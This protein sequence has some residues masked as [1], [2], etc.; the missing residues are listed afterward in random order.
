MLCRCL[1]LLL[2]RKRQKRLWRSVLSRRSLDWRLRRVLATVF[3]TFFT[4]LRVNI[5]QYLKPVFPAVCSIMTSDVSKSNVGTR[6]NRMSKFHK[7][8]SPSHRTLSTHNPVHMMLSPWLTLVS[9]FHWV[10]SQCCEGLSC[11]LCPTSYQT[12]TLGK[13]WPAGIDN[14]V[15]LSAINNSCFYRVNA[16]L[17]CWVE[18]FETH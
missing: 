6:R 4:R 15:I 7:E 18:A 9:L 13:L 1:E 12:I 2:Y 5:D 16:V 17:F 3:V 8:Q 14:D 10:F 11:R